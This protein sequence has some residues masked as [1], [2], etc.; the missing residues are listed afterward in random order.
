M[1]LHMHSEDSGHSLGACTMY[2]SLPSLQR[3]NCV[4]LLTWIA[5]AQL[6]GAMTYEERYAKVI[7]R[8]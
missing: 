4:C 1:Q 5:T 3:S 7:L 8:N 2:S 6:A